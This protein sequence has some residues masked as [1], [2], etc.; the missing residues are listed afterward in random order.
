MND[1]I[2]VKIDHVSKFF[3]LPTEATNSLRTLLVNRLRGIKGYKEQHVLKDI[4]FEVEKGD[5]FGIVGRN[6]S[7]KST[8]LKIISQIYTPEQGSVEIDGKLVSF[9]ELGV[10]FN[11]ELTGREN[12]Y[13]NGAMLGFSRTEIDAMYDDIVDFAELHEFMNQKL[14]NYSSGM[15]VRLAFSVAIKAE[16]DILVLDEVLAVGDESFQRKCNDYFLERKAA[17]KTTILV[18]H[19]MGAAK[20]YCNKA[21]LIEKGLVKVSG[22][23]DEVANQYSL[24]NLQTEV[25][26]GAT[27]ETA[28]DLI[29]NLQLNIL[30]NSKI[31]PEDDIKFEISYDVKKDIETYIA[32]SMTEVDRNIWIYNDNS[33]DYMTQGSGKKRAV[34]SCK[35]DQV[36]D[37]KLKLQVSVR[38]NKDELI[39]FA[40][41][42]VFMINRT[43]L[44]DDDLSAKDSAT[45]LIQRNG[46]WKF[47]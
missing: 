14:K 3:R 30:N 44:A 5:F 31:R 6:G 18:T 34:Y 15:Q 7:G 10:G 45:G 4:S 2:A 19:D 20:K 43:D 23:V 36:N 22:D 28:E 12:V 21:V 33:L 25:S 32:F 42:K 46:G 16:G 27:P 17:G 24:D 47:G 41:E 1:N 26:E 11:P 13:L 9:I 35:L 38:N 37:L 40:D 29:E 39:A 8:L